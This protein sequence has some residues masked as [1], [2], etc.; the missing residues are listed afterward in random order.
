MNHKETGAIVGSATGA[1]VGAG[2][3]R[4]N[5]YAHL[6]V[7][8]RHQNTDDP[9]FESRASFATARPARR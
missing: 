9:A 2:A 6:G 5:P 7:R 1:I 4:N 3:E 8:K